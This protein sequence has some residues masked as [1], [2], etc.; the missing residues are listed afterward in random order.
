MICRNKCMTLYMYV[1]GVELREI[2]PG[3]DPAESKFE[4]FHT[5]LDTFDSSKASELFCFSKNIRNEVTVC[6]K[7]PK[8]KTHKQQRKPIFTTKPIKTCEI[9]P[10]IAL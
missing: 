7:K 10:I 2:Y 4:C 9:I 1:G 5:V 3:S 8:L 6:A